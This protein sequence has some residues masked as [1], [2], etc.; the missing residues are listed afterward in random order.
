MFGEKPMAVGNVSL[1]LINFNPVI[2]FHSLLET[3]ILCNFC[4]RHAAH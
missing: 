2:I 3:L 4:R 1:V